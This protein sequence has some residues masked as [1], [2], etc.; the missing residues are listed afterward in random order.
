MF[1]KRNQLVF[2]ANILIIVFGLSVIVLSDFITIAFLLIA[3]GALLIFEQLKQNKG[4]FSISGLEKTLTVKDTCGTQATLEQKQNTT[5]C[6]VDNTVFWFKSI[7]PMGSV[8]NFSINGQSPV[9]QTKDGNNQYQVCMALP[10]NPRATDGLET[11]LRY[12]YKD[13]FVRT[14]GL[15]THTVDDETDKLRLVVE[16]PEGRRISTA[17]AY[18]IHNGKEEALLPPL[19]SGET[20]IET[21]IDH[22][23]LGAQYCL[24]WTWP[25]ANLLK[26][27]SCFIK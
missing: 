1:D 21:E 4:A 8:G 5:A 13:A 20:R 2:Y 23:K 27:I 14:E 15:L 22:P 6:H 10:A 9:E 26:K 11:V 17:R 7:T 19:I 18:C 16:L 3:C 24:Q 25:E 12:T